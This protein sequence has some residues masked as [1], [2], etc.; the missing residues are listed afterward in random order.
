VKDIFIKGGLIVFSVGII[1]YIVYLF[2]GLLRTAWTPVIK[3]VFQT[4][5]IASVN[6]YQS[7]FTAIGFTL[8]IVFIIGFIFTRPKILAFLRK[9]FKTVSLI[10]M[11]KGSS[12]RAHVSINEKPGALVKFTDGSYYLAAIAGKRKFR[13]RCG[14]IVD[15]YILYSPSSPVPWSG[16][17]VIFAKKENVIPLNLSFAQVYSITTSFGRNAPAIIEEPDMEVDECLYEEDN[18]LANVE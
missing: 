8:I 18:P 7:Y 17:P 15:M 12:S 5:D 11:L 1:V 16:L 3:Y 2:L 4:D 14:D 6:I 13:D 9:A 10:Q